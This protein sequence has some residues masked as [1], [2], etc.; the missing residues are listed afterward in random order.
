MIASF[1]DSFPDATKAPELSFFPCFSIYML[2]KVFTTTV[3]N[4]TKTI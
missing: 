3:I 4:N 1:L 2:R